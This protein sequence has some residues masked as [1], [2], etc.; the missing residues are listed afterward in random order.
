MPESALGLGTEEEQSA[1]RKPQKGEAW[2]LSHHLLKVLVFLVA[3]RLRN[4]I[5]EVHLVNLLYFILKSYRIE[6]NKEIGMHYAQ[7]LFDALHKKSWWKSQG[8]LKSHLLE[9]DKPVLEKLRLKYP[10]PERGQGG[11]NNA[12]KGTRANLEPKR[13]RVWQ[14]GKWN[15]TGNPG[16]APRKQYSRSRS[17]S[18]KGKD[19]G[20][21]KKKGGP[22]GKTDK[23]KG[24][25]GGKPASHPSVQK[26]F[27]L[28]KDSKGKYCP[29]AQTGTCRFDPCR[30]PHIC[31]ICKS[32]SHGA[33]RC[34]DL[35][36]EVGKKRLGL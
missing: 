26:A 31:Y 14:G 20:G 12:G 15:K 24:G 8:T 35:V 1:A 7:A 22:K 13:P 11:K 34:F 5:D 9:F 36:N 4:Q 25:K 10:K 27:Q 6:Q 33:Y 30:H 17:R 29:W 2:G 28:A 19:E 3:M 18:R 16:G 32:S 21:G 23:D